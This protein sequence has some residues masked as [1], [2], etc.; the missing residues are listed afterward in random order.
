VAL[1]NSRLMF[2][3]F[4]EIAYSRGGKFFE[5]KKVFVEQL[6]IVKADKVV[7]RKLE[8]LVDQIQAAKAANPAADVA[9]IE[10]EIDQLVYQLYGLTKEEIKIVEGGTN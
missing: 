4:E 8:A 5:F 10:S 9:A 6:P 1:L 7:R 2:F 3:V